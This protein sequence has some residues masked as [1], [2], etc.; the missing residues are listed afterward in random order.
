M[1]DSLEKTEV[2]VKAFA[3]Y[4]DLY[5]W[6]AG[7]G[8]AL[9]SCFVVLSN[10]RLLRD[11]IAF[12]MKLS[13]PHMLY[14]V[15]LV[16]VLVMVM[17]HGSL[18]RTRILARFA[19]PESPWHHRPRHQSRHPVG[20]NRSDHPCSF[21]RCGG[22]GRVPLQD[23]GGQTVEQKGV[24]IMVCLDCSRSMLAQDIKPHPAGT[25]KAGRSLIFWA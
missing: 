15:W 5:R 25:G 8:L 13:H 1:I 6:F 11:P 4:N 17:V 22:S 24:D 20:Q 14:L 10:T 3:E 2:E 9:L 16:A 21:L 23:S 18:K 7:A 12:K 19:A